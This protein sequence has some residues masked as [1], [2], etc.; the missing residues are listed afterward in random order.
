MKTILTIA[1]RIT[2]TAADL[3]EAVIA[4]L[5]EQLTFLNPKYQENEKFGRWNGK[6]PE[7]L[8]YL[9]RVDGALII[10]RGFTRQLLRILSNNHIV[11]AID[12]KTRF[13]PDVDFEFNGR[14]HNY[15]AEAVQKIM[16]RRYGVLQAPTGGGKTVIALSVTAERKQPTLIIVHSKELMYQWRARIE[17]F[18]DIPKA[19]IGLIGDSRKSIGNRITIGIVNSIK[20]CAGEIK[21]RIGLLIVDEAHRTPSATFAEAI[22]AF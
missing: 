18:L 3:S 1:N 8:C 20:K 13:M 10:P 4:K 12:D 11:H 17:Q 14:L 6:T 5:Q 19:E 22:Q 21:G 7:E 9:E 16:A 2:I 15:Q